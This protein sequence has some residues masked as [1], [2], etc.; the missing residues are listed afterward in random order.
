M[1]PML[2]SRSATVGLVLLA[3]AALASSSGGAVSGVTVPRTSAAHPCGTR[4]T[5]PPVWRH[6]VWIVMENKSFR[7][8]VGSR[9]APYLNGLA[10]RCGVATNFHSVGR[11]SLPNYIALTS[12]STQGIADDGSPAVHRPAVPSLFS[13]LGTQWRAL[14]ESM[15]SACA[16]S[17]WGLYAVRHNPA[18]YGTPAAGG[19]AGARTC[20]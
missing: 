17:D 18:A 6:V 4:R 15:P 5:P 14:V 9:D 20:P 1:P 13:Q 7:Q 16:L 8:V 11:P 3:A 2:R 10:R 19:R 12:G